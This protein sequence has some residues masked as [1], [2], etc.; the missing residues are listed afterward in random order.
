MSTLKMEAVRCSETSVY[1]CKEVDIAEKNVKGKVM[2]RRMSIILFENSQAS[3]LL[4]R[5]V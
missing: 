2:G 5:S 3:V 4:I 1:R